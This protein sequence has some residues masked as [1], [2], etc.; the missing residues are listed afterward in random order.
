MTLGPALLLLGVFEKGI[1]AAGRPA[2]TIGRVPLFYY[3]MHILI[4]HLLT[5][6]ASYLRFGEVHWMFE[7]PTIA[8]FPIT[9][10]PGWPVGLPVVYLIWVGVVLAL[11]PICRWFA[12]VKQRHP[13]RWLSYL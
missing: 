12:G 1:P 2:L 10:P 13:Q 4:I 6:V 7:S 8:Q 11:Y 9:Q 5:V 3:M